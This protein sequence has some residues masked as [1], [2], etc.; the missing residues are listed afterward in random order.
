MADLFWD[1][2][3]VEDTEVVREQI[4]D[5]LQRKECAGRKLRVEAFSEFALAQSLIQSRK[6]DLLILDIIEGAPSG[7]EPAPTP[8]LE[9]LKT[10]KESIFVP[11]IIYTAAPESV[12]DCAAPFVA[13]IGKDE[14]L[15]VIGAKIDEFFALRL[16]QVGRAVR[17]HLE[18]VTCAYMWDFVQKHWDASFKTLVDKPE[19]V[20]ILLQR[21]ARSVSREQIAKVEA[22]VYGAKEEAKPGDAAADEFVHPVEMYVMPPLGENPILG[23]IRVKGAGAE[24][25]HWVVLWPSC[26]LVSATGRPP[27]TEKVLCAKG[28][29]LKASLEYVAWAKDKT[30]STATEKLTKLFKNNRESSK[31]ITKERFHYLPAIADMPDLVVDFQ[32]LAHIPLEELRGMN[33]LATLASPFAE[34]MAARFSSYLL[35]LGTPDLDLAHVIARLSS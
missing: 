3:V 21:L 35:R 18:R 6:V 1:V 31:G 25:E 22:E 5:F 17:A 34:S 30:S 20:R 8:G 23:D 19:F 24:A 14:K 15:A 2:V 10:I 33:R 29:S 28:L 32:E 26:D 7:A 11:V 12:K 4:K 27:K 16:P 9:I 13:V